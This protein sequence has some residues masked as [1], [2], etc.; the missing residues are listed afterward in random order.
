MNVSATSLTPANIHKSQSVG[1]DLSR[2]AV[3]N[4]IS[5]SIDV[6]GDSKFGV[7]E[8]LKLTLK[9]AVSTLG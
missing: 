7:V 4:S 1:A 6:N 3:E 5:P 2:Q 8:P 9:R